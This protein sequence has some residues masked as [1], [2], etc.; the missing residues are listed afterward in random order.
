MTCP[1]C[2]KP[3]TVSGKL[4]VC[5]PCRDFVIVLNV[6]SKFV[7]PLPEWRHVVQREILDD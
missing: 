2:S 6:S 4:F 1:Q 3:M 7:P 5:E